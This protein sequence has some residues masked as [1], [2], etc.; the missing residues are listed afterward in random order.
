MITMITTFFRDNMPK[1]IT[2]SEEDRKALVALYEDAQTTPAILFD[3][4]HPDLATIAWMDVRRKFDELGK[5]YG[6]NPKQI[7][8]INKVTGEILL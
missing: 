4:S 2:L 8:G 1:T 7:K 3:Y 5:K 6:F